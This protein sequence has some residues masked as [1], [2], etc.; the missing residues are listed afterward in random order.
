[1]EENKNQTA[2]HRKFVKPTLEVIDMTPCAIVS[3][4]QPDETPHLGPLGKSF[5]A[6]SEIETMGWDD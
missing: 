5:E 4:S 1:M 2:T 3:V 6:S